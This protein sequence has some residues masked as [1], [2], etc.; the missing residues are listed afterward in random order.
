MW[1]QNASALIL[2]F[3]AN[4]SNIT[5]NLAEPIVSIRAQ[6]GWVWRLRPPGED[7]SSM[8]WKVLIMTKL[9][10]TW[11]YQRVS[12]RSARCCRQTRT[13][14]Q[15]TARFAKERDGQHRKKPEEIAI[16]GKFKLNKKSSKPCACSIALILVL[17]TTSVVA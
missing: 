2:V 7:M 1:T 5:I 9:T 8:G 16:E 10:A 4:I 12:G 3:Q 15:L 13:A 14:Q 6:P 11:R 17:G